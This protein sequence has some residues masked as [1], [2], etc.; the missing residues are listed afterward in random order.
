[1]YTRLASTY[2]TS[3]AMRAKRTDSLMLGRKFKTRR[4]RRAV[5]LKELLGYH[6]KR[7][8]YIYNTVDSGGCIRKRHSSAP[9]CHSVSVQHTARKRRT[10]RRSDAPEEHVFRTQSPEVATHAQT[11]YVISMYLLFSK[12]NDCTL[13]AGRQRA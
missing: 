11:C 8:E 10:E 1:M 2:R 12:Q 9:E 5:F 7:I 3:A 6:G 4:N 13:T